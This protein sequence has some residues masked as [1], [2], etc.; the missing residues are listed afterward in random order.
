MRLSS[1]TGARPIRT[2]ASRTVSTRRA[3]YLP[4][5]EVRQEGSRTSRR[6]PS[7]P[8]RAQDAVLAG[9][10]VDVPG[11]LV[12]T[13]RGDDVQRP[14]GEPAAR[15]EPVDRPARL[16]CR[17]R[18]ARRRGRAWRRRGVGWS[19]RIFALVKFSILIP[20]Y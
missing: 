4:V 9:G 13:A 11:E 3:A 19:H 14:A 5:G 2:S 1:A 6:S 15:G 7:C 18:L 17:E 12:G 10:N 16:D 8:T 20:V